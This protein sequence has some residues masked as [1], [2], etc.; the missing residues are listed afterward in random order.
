MTERERVLSHVILG[1]NDVAKAFE[2]FD[3]LDLDGNKIVATCHEAE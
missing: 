1:T 3:Q 2:F